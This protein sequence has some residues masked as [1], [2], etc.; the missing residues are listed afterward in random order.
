MD[1]KNS[2]VDNDSGQKKRNPKP[3][4]KRNRKR[5]RSEIHPNDDESH[6][7]AKV[8][9]LTLNGE[10]ISGG[11]EYLRL[12][13]PYRYN[14]TS[15][16]KARWVGNSVLD[17]YTS[18]FGGYPPSYYEMAITQ[19]RILVSDK[20]VETSHVIKATDVL[21]HCVHRHEPAVALHFNEPPYVK[22]AADTDDIVAI[23]KPGTL[24]IH[25]C[26]GYHQNS[27]MKILEKEE[28]YAKLYTIHRLDRLTSGLV[29]LGKTSQVARAWGKAIQQREDCEKLYLARVSGRFPVKCPE[30]VP[31]LASSLIKPLYGEWHIQKSSTEESN[32]VENCRQRNAWGYWIEDSRGCQERRQS[33]ASLSSVTRDIERCLSE[34]QE[35]DPSSSDIF[36]WLRLACPVRVAEQKRGVCVSVVS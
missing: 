11:P 27:L 14:F 4:S 26:G 6:I 12:I 23:D 24:P 5:P 32:T 7:E 25:P 2:R 35:K 20:R 21:V 1:G 28:K 30:T 36:Q 10:K 22:I 31:C 18:E 33:F 13:V 9:P 34:L 16:A 19:G 15:H 29:I 17:V 8:I 3:R